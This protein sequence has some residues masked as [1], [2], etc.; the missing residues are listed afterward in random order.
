MWNNIKK[1]IKNV[2]DFLSNNYKLSTCATIVERRLKN[3]ANNW[4]QYLLV[5]ISSFLVR[6]NYFSNFCD[7]WSFTFFYHLLPINFSCFKNLHIN[8]PCAF[9]CLFVH[10][11][12]VVNS[13]HIVAGGN[14]VVHFFSLL[15]SILLYETITNYLTPSVDE[16]WMGSVSCMLQIILIW[17]LVHLLLCLYLYFCSIN[18][19]TGWQGYEIWAI[20][21]FF[22]SN[23]KND[24]S[25]FSS[26]ISIY[27]VS[28]I[29]ESSHF[30]THV[31]CLLFDSFI[32]VFKDSFSCL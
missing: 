12:V 17:T 27:S 5:T 8:S 10:N 31:C 32:M 26:D 23:A 22:L 24:I 9:L 14:S 16:L 18:W 7:N 29:E 11:T 13:V 15:C 2:Y 6:S 20:F 25:L 4:A 21:T 1:S 30:L 19:T 28:S 3:I